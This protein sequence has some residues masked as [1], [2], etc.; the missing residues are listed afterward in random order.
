MQGKE[1]LRDPLLNKGSAF[2]QKER[3]A[4]QLNGLLPAH[5]STMSE[6]LQRRYHNFSKKNSR[7]EKYEFL[8]N[9]QNRNEILYYRLILEHVIEMLPFVYTP[10]VGDISLLYSLQYNQ[11]RGL[12]IQWELQDRIE[13]ILKNAPSKDID[14]IVVTDGGRVL[15]LGDVGVGGMV[16]PI[17]KAALYTIFGG[18]HPARILPIMLDVGTDNET[19]LNDPLYIGSKRKRITGEEYY[20]F[21]EKFVAAVKKVFPH[22]LLQWEDFSRDHS[23]TLLNRYKHRICSFNDDIQGTAAVTLAGLLA[24]VDKKKSHIFKEKIAIYGAGSAGIGIANIIVDYCEHLGSSR[25][26]AFSRIYMLDTRGLIHEGLSPLSQEHRT[27]ARTS[28]EIGFWSGKKK[29]EITLQDVIENAGITA[30]IGVSTHK[31]AFDKKV[32]T[33][34]LKNT[35][36]PIIFPLSNPNSK[37]EATVDQIFRWVGDKAIIATGSPFPDIEYKGVVHSIAQ[38]NNVYIFPAIGLAA[39]A[40]KSREVTQRQFLVA[41]AALSEK[42]APFLFPPFS[43]LREVIEHIATSVAKSA[44][45]EGLASPPPGKSVE[46]AI[47]EKMWFPS[48]PTYE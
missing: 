36:H 44:I 24:A 41:A 4:L 18:I 40:L 19:L 23:F 47:Q 43:R 22:A 10:T 6:Q 5:I 39:A 37:A 27:L 46:Q 32:V 38:C 9:L 7:V 16:I 30:L 48:Y 20:L 2:T 11:T 28:N 15:G 13:E 8:S 12:F 45:E 14:V 42:S 25:E 31:G 26:E 21:L 1:I 34:M 3:D 33:A 35:D 17:G 29:G